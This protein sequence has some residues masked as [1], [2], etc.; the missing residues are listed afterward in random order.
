MLGLYY[1]IWVNCIERE[2]AR[3]PN[4]SVWKVRSIIFMTLAMSFN[5]LLLISIFQRY[6]SD[7]FFYSIE[8]KTLPPYIANVFSYVILFILPFLLLN[9]I[10]IFKGKRYKTLLNKYQTKNDSIFIIYFSI[11]MLLPIL[12]MW[13][14]I[15]FS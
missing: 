5:L 13:I 9:Y 4:G 6:I 15:I 11:S 8:F 12:L 3:N 1:K 10:L 7:S 2:M 14:G